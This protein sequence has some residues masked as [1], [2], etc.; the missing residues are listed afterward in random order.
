MTAAFSYLAPG[1]EFPLW[2]FPRL[3]AFRSTISL[4]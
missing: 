1:S 2:L 3:K 4:R